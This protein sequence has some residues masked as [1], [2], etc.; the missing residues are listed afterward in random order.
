ML[1]APGD[2]RPRSNTKSLRCVMGGWPI[3]RKLFVAFLAVFS[4]TFFL[5]WAASGWLLRGV[6]HRLVEKELQSSTMALESLV[7]TSVDASINSYL[8]G[9]AEKNT[10]IIASLHA[11][12]QSG[13]MKEAAA[14]RCATDILLSQHIGS[15]GY[16][17]VLGSSNCYA[18]FCL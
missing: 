16:I 13:K 2:I 3:Q 7:K 12:V 5:N 17:H 15:S 8:R 1:P 14:Q 11:Q 4:V 6:V 18:F 10:E 9:I